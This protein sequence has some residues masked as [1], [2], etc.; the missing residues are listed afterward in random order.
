MVV[1]SKEQKYIRASIRNPKKTAGADIIYNGKAIA[2]VGEPLQGK[3]RVVGGDEAAADLFGPH[4]TQSEYHSERLMG[5]ILTFRLSRHTVLSF[6][7]RPE[8]DEETD[9]CRPLKALLYKE[10]DAVS[11]LFA[12]PNTQNFLIKLI[13][14][15]SQR[16][17]HSPT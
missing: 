1:S 6:K 8:P 7:R 12:L 10:Q 9:R 3:S 11:S 13:H 15:S 14:I 2:V 17:S 5:L 4:R 16:N